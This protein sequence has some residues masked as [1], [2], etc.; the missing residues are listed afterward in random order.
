[1]ATRERFMICRLET[2][3]M[4]NQITGANSR[5]ASPIK[6]GRQ[7]GSASCAPPSPSAAVAQ[8]WR[9]VTENL[10]SRNTT[11]RFI[12]FTLAALAIA[13]ASRLTGADVPPNRSAE[14]Q[15]LDRF[16][17]TWETVFTIKAT[18]EQIN[19]VENRKWSQK[20]RFVLSEDLN[21]STGKEAHFLI[22]YDPNVRLYRSC[23]IEEGNA[24]VLLGTWDEDTATMK[25]N[26]TDAHGTKHAAT[27]RF[28]DKDHVEW[29]MAVTGPD[30]KVLVELSANQ[31]RRKP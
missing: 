2:L 8:F 16:I 3:S 15:V 6:A 19:S 29:S 7:F 9:S 5:P 25:W 13:S 12:A 11:M 21:A 22:T 10:N 28:I 4:A 26:S 20:G 17:G 31:E 18:G 24:V 1:M 14:L 27:Y 23:F 30:G